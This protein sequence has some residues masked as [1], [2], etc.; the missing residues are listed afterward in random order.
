[1][2]SRTVRLDVDLDPL[3]VGR[4]TGLLWSRPKADDP[5]PGLAGVG[6]AIRLTVARPDGGRAAQAEVAALAGPNEVEGPGTGPVAFGAFPFDRTVPGEL[7]VPRVIVGRGA[8]GRRWLTITDDGSLS[9]DDAV[10]LVRA[11][12]DYS[13]GRAESAESAGR[14]ERAESGEASTDGPGEPTVYELTSPLAPELWRDEVVAVVRD[15]IRAGELDKAVLARELVLR[16]DAPVPPALVLER[17]ADAFPAAIL[18]AV[19]GFLGATPELL[20]ARHGDIVRA[21]PLAGTAPRATDPSADGRR[22]AALLA[23]TKDRWEH[24]I[25]IDWLLDGLLPFCSYV[26]AEPE[27]TIVSLAN[28]HHLGTRV[29]G[30]LSSPPVSAL[31]LVEALHP[32]PAVGGAPQAVALDVIAELE[33]AERGRY[34]GPV[35]WVDAE[36]NGA[37]AVGI[38]SAVMDGTEVRLFAGVGVVGD[39]DPAAELAETRAKFRAMLGALLRP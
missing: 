26:D 17:L 16:T 4:R 34:A 30:R 14:A 22:A 25:T 6:E 39:S 2:K 37:F 27:P 21:H 20:V 15:R 9:V 29:E 12:L 5:V 24:R 11:T 36:G 38:R 8:D 1:M 23:S 31:E 18:F 19:D 7:V 35:G 3:A 28:V 10:A 32:T 13:A 33:Q